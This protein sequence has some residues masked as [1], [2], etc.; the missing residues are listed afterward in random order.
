MLFA[1]ELSPEES[2]FLLIGA[3]FAGAVCGLWP[4]GAGIR[5]RRPGVAVTGFIA[6]LISGVVLGCLLALP[7]AIFFRL[8]IGVL[9]PPP[10]PGGDGMGGEPFNPYA[11]GK[12][13][14]W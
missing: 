12:R 14:E 8:L 6:C 7:T 1:N 4:L 11:H 3:L 13:S 2:V 9:D 5:K 10:M